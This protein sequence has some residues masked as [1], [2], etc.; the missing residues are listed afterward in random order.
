M[1]LGQEHGGAT[2]VPK[3]PIRSGIG[4]KGWM[5]LLTV[6]CL[7]APGLAQRG[8]APGLGVDG[9][10]LYREAGSVAVLAQATD[11]WQAVSSRTEELQ[12]DFRYLPEYASARSQGQVFRVLLTD[13]SS[14]VPEPGSDFVVVPWSFGPGCA[15]EGWASPRWVPPGDTVSFL[16]LPTRVRGRR[17]EAMAVFDV[18][19]WHQPYP[20]GELIP[21]WRRTPGPEP[22]WLTA[23]EFFQVLTALPTQMALEADPGPALGQ[24]RD[25]LARSP[26]FVGAFPVT[27]MVAGWEDAWGVRMLADPVPWAPENR[28]PVR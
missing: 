22:R 12:G 6:F 13:R 16:L 7:P 5:A 24:M 11:L 8:D 1:R 10:P 27:E 14:V 2:L 4:L 9:L 28:R 3:Q 25:L 20:V 17:D 21:F 23:P 18:L 19:G 26:G 15:E